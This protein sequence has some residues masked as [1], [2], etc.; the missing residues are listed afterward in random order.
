MSENDQAKLLA[1]K[2]ALK[3]ENA[4][5]AL[6]TEMVLMEWPAEYRA[7]MWGAVVE[8]ARRMEAAAKRKK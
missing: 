7:I 8:Y 3:A 1:D 4:L 6:R 5:S 2:I